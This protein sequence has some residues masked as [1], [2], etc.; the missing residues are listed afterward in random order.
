MQNFTGPGI[1][2]G[3]F[4]T[5]HDVVSGIANFK[6]TT[7]ALFFTDQI[8]DG[9]V[10]LKD[11]VAKIA[12]ELRQAFMPKHE[13]KRLR[14][15]DQVWMRLQ[16]PILISSIGIIC[17]A[18]FVCTSISLKIVFPEVVLKRPFC[19]DW[20]LQPLPLNVKGGV[21]G[22]SDLFPGAFF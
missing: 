17:L 14:E 9:S 4:V 21:A 13:Y 7:P 10:F 16:R 12:D 2:C 6:R 8:K 3:R 15:E 5:T 19:H 18:V 20:R 11:S 22:D 1:S